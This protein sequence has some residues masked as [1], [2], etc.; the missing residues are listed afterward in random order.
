MSRREKL[1]TLIDIIYASGAMPLYFPLM[2]IHFQLKCRNSVYR[3]QQKQYKE[4]L[5]NKS[6]EILYCNLFAKD[7]RKLSL[8]TLF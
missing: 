3:A 7:D 4:M 1:K 5:E 2:I 8:L 6:I